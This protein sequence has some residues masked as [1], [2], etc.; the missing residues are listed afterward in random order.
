[1]TVALEEGEWSA[2][3]PGCT[4]PPRKTQ[5][6]FFRR[7]GGPQGW[8]GRSKYLVPTG[9]RSWTVQPVVSC[10]T[11]W[12]TWPT[13]KRNTYLFCLCN[14]TYLGPRTS[15][16]PNS[17]THSH[18]HTHTHTLSLTDSLTL[19]HT[20]TLSHTHTHTLTLTL[21]HTHT[22]TQNYYNY[23]HLKYLIFTK[24]YTKL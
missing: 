11:D 7:L 12:A 22:H 10:Y 8:S 1:M 23:I 18:T 20:H 24:H 2:A 14:I 19:T 5:Y 15:I 9:I 21:T 6:P 17:H 4:L 3:H 13:Y 16:P